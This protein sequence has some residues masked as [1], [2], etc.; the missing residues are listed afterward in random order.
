MMEEKRQS[1]N[2]LEI[3]NLIIR[4]I[5]DD[6]TVYAVNGIDITIP[7]GKTVGLVGETGAAGKGYF[8]GSPAGRK[9]RSE[10]VSP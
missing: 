2:T 1:D 4:Y 9:G 3:K 8:R 6:E 7:R 10:N 5:S